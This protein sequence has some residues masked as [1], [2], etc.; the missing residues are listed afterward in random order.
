LLAVIP[1]IAIAQD[2]G[3]IKIGGLFSLSSWAAEG[4]KQELNSAVLAVEDINAN[5]GINGRR[6]KLVVE[7]N[8]SDLKQTVSAF[9]KLEALD[10]VSAIIG[11]NWAEFV[12]I[13]APLAAAKRIP[14]LTPSGYHENNS[15][16]EPW[17]FVLWP[18]P[19]NAAG[20]LVDEMVRREISKVSVLL[21]ENTY[22]QSVWRAL[23]SKLTERGILVVDKMSF[24][25]GLADYRSA[26]QR[27]SAGPSQAVIPLLLESGE[28]A[29]FLKQRQE[30]KLALPLFGAN[31]IPFDPIVGRDLALA[32]GLTY[33]DYIVLGSD[34]F[35]SRYRERFKSEPGFASAKAYDAVYLI[36]N[37]IK[38]CGLER[39]MIRTCLQR[40]R[41]DGISGHVEFNDRGLIVAPQ[42]NSKLF[43]VVDGKLGGNF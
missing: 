37:A 32:N 20:L 22:Y 39:Q 9:R 24:A 26:I 31:T 8:G 16:A 18:S 30:Q 23:E 10:K 13:A 14:I 27:V 6:I 2:Q 35:I 36:A 43:S 3:E 41:F 21:S 38:E 4:G 11:P 17:T 15:R 29:A 1:H 12:A 33:F 19:S 28:L 40:A 34:D 25:P 42:L 7:D 5:G